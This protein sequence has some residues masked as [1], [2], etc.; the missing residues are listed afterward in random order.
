[1]KIVR[2]SYLLLLLADSFHQGKQR[3]AHLRLVFV[4]LLCQTQL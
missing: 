4:I 1:M 2:T 3:I